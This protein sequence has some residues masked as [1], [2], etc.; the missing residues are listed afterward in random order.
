[1]KFFEKFISTPITL[2]LIFCAFIVSACN[3][4]DGN[5]K[6]N[7]TGKAGEVVVVIDKSLWDGA[8]G[9]ALREVLGKDYPALN[10]REPSFNLINIPDKAFTN[11]FQSHRNIVMVSLNASSPEKKFNI[12]KDVWAYPQIVVNIR[13]QSDSAV[14]ELVNENANLLFNA[15]DQIEKDRIINNCKR[16]EEAEVRP[17]VAE[18]FGGSPYFANGYKIRKQGDNFIWVGYETSYTIQGILIYTIPFNG[19]EFPEKE[20]IVAAQ[21]SVLKVNVPGMMENSYMTISNAPEA[22]LL[23]TN[24]KYKGANFVEIRGLWEVENDF[25]GGPF[26]EHVRYAKDY[27][28]LLVIQGFV[29]APRYNKRN[30]LRQVEAMIYSFEWKENFS[31]K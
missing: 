22:E 16:Y 29:Y 30:Y 19:K 26:V 6:K 13:A 5:Y 9:E 20:Q 18:M 2:L 25:M 24:Y 15:I 8:S 23:M 3:G 7:V 31:N 14:A 17:V 4:G 1:M 28:K 27:G 21:D 11:L 10:Q 12:Q